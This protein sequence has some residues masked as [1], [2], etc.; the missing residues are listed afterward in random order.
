[1]TLVITKFLTANTKV[2]F[3]V[4][5]SKNLLIFALTGFKATNARIDTIGK[6]LIATPTTIPINPM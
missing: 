4:C 3:L 2:S 6:I 1:M 5:S